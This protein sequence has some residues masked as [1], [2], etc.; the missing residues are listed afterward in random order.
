MHAASTAALHTET[1]DQR[2]LSLVRLAVGSRMRISRGRRE[3]C[4]PFVKSICEDWGMPAAGM[5]TDRMLS[6]AQ[7]PPKHD[8]PTRFK[9]LSTELKQRKRSLQ[10]GD[11]ITS[12]N[13][14]G[15]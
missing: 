5:P 9:K 14:Q 2:V 8:Y 4:G 11:T 12:S 1:K 7:L 6:L 13:S 15:I 10:V 3:L